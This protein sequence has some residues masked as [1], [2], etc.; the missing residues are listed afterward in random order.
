MPRINPSKGRHPGHISLSVSE[1]EIKGLIDGLQ[2]YDL[3]DRDIAGT[4]AALLEAQTTERLI[5]GGPSPSGIPWEDWSPG[6]KAWRGKRGGHQWKLRLTDNMLGSIVSGP[7]G[8]RAQVSVRTP[9]AAVH[10][11]GGGNNIPARPYLGMT[12]KNADEI[13]EALGAMMATE[14]QA[15]VSGRTQGRNA[16]LRPGR[17]MRGTKGKGSSIMARIKRRLFA[18]LSAASQGD[19]G[20]VI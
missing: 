19:G 17:A 9:Y 8:S 16:V 18:S 12:G 10:Q 7:L 5:A 3:N 15:A 14:F 6:Y 4:I 1:N 11:K 2:A 13:A 20:P